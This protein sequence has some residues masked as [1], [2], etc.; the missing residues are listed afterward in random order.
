M[1]LYTKT[2]EKYDMSAWPAVLEAKD[3]EKAVGLLALYAEA[4]KLSDEAHDAYFGIS[5]KTHP[6]KKNRCAAE[7]AAFAVYNTNKRKLEEALTALLVE[8][9][10][11]EEVRAMQERRVEV[12]EEFE[13]QIQADLD[14][15]FD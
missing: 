2:L 9:H 14:A 11:E 4:L 10:G 12:D 7:D 6:I 5:K 3:V 8:L 15:T 1:E 13:A